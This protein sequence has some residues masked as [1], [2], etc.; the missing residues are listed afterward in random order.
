MSTLQKI[1]SRD[2]DRVKNARRVRDGRIGGK[3][4][5]EGLRLIGEAAKSRTHI[6]SLF[7]TD[8]VLDQLDGDELH[9]WLRP[10]RI[11]HVPDPILQSMA[12]TSTSQGI[13]AIADP[14]PS[15]PELFEEV[16]TRTVPVVVFLNQINN[17]SNLGAI[18]RTAEAAGV[19]GVIVS[20]G[21][22]D[23][24]S[25]KALRAS[26]GSTLRVPVWIDVEF[27]D[28]INWARAKRLRTVAADVSGSRS[29][30]SVDWQIPRM[31]VL[32]SEAHGLDESM[33][34]K[35]DEVV[36]IPMEKDVESLNL[37]V[38]CGVILFEARRQAADR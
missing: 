11:Y 17:P 18:M 3:I 27:G 21:S 25:P 31:L 2:N 5:L 6:D 23:V 14:P 15:G 1:T 22:A 24:F 38:A 30:A 12:D 7:V 29:Y 28:A 26:M 9:S 34:A 37:A 19:A 13:I 4:F 35:I 16:H 36:L 32:G 33:L 20:S 8:D 10:E